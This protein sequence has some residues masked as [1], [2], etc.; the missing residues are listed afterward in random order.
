MLLLLLVAFA[1]YSP[2]AAERDLI[3]SGSNNNRTSLK[4]SSALVNCAAGTY[5]EANTCLGCPTGSTSYD[6]AFTCHA[7]DGYIC[8][9]FGVT[10]SCFNDTR[11]PVAVTRPF[12][13]NVMHLEY[14]SGVS[15]FGGTTQVISFSFH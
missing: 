2:S 8:S 12:H 14:W 13:S 9:G 3:F 5:L 15:S 4:S 7:I 6:G 10:L 11:S 1:S